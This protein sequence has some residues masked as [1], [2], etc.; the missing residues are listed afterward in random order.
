ML[1]VSS[2]HFRGH[3]LS[4]QVTEDTMTYSVVASEA[5]APA[6]VVTVE[7][8]GSSHPLAVGSPVSAP[9]GRAKISLK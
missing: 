5:A 6:L 3:R 7:A 9:R 8:D 4:Q 2:F 1:G